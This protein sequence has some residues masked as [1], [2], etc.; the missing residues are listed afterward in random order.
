MMSAKD[1]LL[2]LFRFLGIL[3]LQLG[4][5]QHIDIRG[6]GIPM[7]YPLFILL[8]PVYSS[9]VLLLILAFGL[10]YIIDVATNGGGINTASLVAM[11]YSRKYVLTLLKPLSGY[12][13]ESIPSITFFGMQWFLKY[14]IISILIHQLSFYF[15]DAMSLKNFFYT[16]LRG[17][18]GSFI[19]IIIIWII[20]LLFVSTK[21]RRR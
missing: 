15:L 20:Y 1:I 13:K 12:E 8:L 6:F 16:L 11:A 3:L 4:I 2:I 14:L 18:S 5:L 10:G 19:T 21:R 9:P 17:L 7:I